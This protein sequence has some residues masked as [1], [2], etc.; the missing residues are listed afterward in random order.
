LLQRLAQRPFPR[1]L[2]ALK[3]QEWPRCRQLIYQRLYQRHG[4]LRLQDHDPSQ[5][6]Q[7]RVN[8]LLS[9]RTDRLTV[10]ICWLTLQ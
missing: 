8:T 3:N 10:L 6:W 7:Q 4:L 1:L 2:L 5:V 9:E